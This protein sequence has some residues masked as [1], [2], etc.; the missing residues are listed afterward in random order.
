MSWKKLCG[1]LL[2]S[3]KPAQLYSRTFNNRAVLS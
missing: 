1:S 3:K 2:L